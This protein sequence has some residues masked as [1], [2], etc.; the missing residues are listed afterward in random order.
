MNYLIFIMSHNTKELTDYVYTTLKKQTDNVRVLENSYL[1]ER[2]FL[3]DDTIDFGPENIGMGGF[4]DYVIDNYGD[5]NDYFIG[6]FNNDIFNIP[7]DYIEKITKYL[8]PEYGIIHSALD[9]AGCPYPHM[10][11]N[12]STNSRV[13]PFIETVAP[14]FNTKILKE[15]QKFVPTHYYGW[16]DVPMSKISLKLGL[17]NIIVDEI[18]ISHE[19]SG[20]R[21]RMEE[22]DGSLTKFWSEVGQ[23]LNEWK[24]KHPELK[25]IIDSE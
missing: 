19:R 23:T 5:L 17:K 24:E 4:Y 2:K 18:T 6:I 11:K 3:N 10:F 25:K 15:M 16:T 9:D 1:N 22:I 12:P 13:V 14:F 21:K 7:E 20:V 8:S